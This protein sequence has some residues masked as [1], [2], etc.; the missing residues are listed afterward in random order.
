[1]IISQL[2][3]AR[4]N[5][6][7]SVK[8]PELNYAHEWRYWLVKCMLFLRV[9][10]GTFVL[11]IISLC[12][13]ANNVGDLK[14]LTPNFFL[15]GRSLCVV[16]VFHMYIDLMFIWNVTKEILQYTQVWIVQHL[17]RQLNKLVLWHQLNIHI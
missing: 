10:E 15:K 11:T 1:M 2:L 17:L 6:P 12:S 4:C 7:T 13:N 9:L 5:S 8:F 3:T 14:I 16:P